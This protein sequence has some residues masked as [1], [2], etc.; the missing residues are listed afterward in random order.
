MRSSSL[1]V[2]GGRGKSVAGQE[3]DRVLCR[4]L[5]GAPLRPHA[6]LLLPSLLV[7]SARPAGPVCAASLSCAAAG[8]AQIHK[9]QKVPLRTA[10]Y[11]RALQS[12]TR[13]H[14]QRGFD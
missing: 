2:G 5:A 6:A 3:D 10:A 11:V 8:A 4:D 14:I 13:A 9:D 12:V 7:L 1:Q